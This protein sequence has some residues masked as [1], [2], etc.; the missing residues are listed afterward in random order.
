MVS[1]HGGSASGVGDGGG[2]VVGGLIGRAL[3]FNTNVSV[4]IKSSELSHVAQW[5][6]RVPAVRLFNTIVDSFER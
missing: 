1:Y 6:V 2:V 4:E 3:I 5:Y